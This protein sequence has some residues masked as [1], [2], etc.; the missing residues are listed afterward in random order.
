MWPTLAPVGFHSSNALATP[1]RDQKI[2]NKN[3]NITK[4]KK[5]Q[6]SHLEPSI[7]DFVYIIGTRNIVN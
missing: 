5:T 1:K 7:I 2:K 6:E 3:D 4:T